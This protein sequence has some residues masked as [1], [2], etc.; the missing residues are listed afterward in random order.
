MSSSFTRSF[1]LLGL[2]LCGLWSVIARAA[3][4][5]MVTVQHAATV[6]QG[7]TVFLS[8]TAQNATAVTVR[9]A[10]KTAP[11]Q[12]TKDGYW[13]AC[14][15][16]A[17]TTR[18]GGYQAAIDAQYDG[19]S[20]TTPTTFTVTKRTFPVQRLHMSSS[21]EAKYSAPS[22]QEEY[23]LIFAALARETPRAWHGAFALPVAGR[24]STAYGVQRYR[25]GKRVSVHKGVDLAAPKGTVVRAANAGT[26]VLRREFGMHGHTLVVDHG[27]GVIGLYLHLSDFTVSEG[28]TVRAGDTIAHVGSTGVATG[29]H[30]HY[31]LYV[32]G[33]AVDPLL[34]K[35]VPDGW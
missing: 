9:F 31:A 27:G 6:A 22:V 18:P 23:R 21:E 14:L 35:S 10:G 29:P 7:G 2:A 8:I 1:P 12:A 30:L 28:Q 15:G 34:W 25:N 33:V 26:V 19:H 5:P 17:S 4:P 32:H 20:I 24:L 13:Q 11:A 16:I 3:A